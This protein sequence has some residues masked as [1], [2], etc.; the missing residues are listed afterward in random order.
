[1]ATQ[2][3]VRLIFEAV[4]RY[5]AVTDDLIKQLD[6]IS[7]RAD[8]AQKGAQELAESMRRDVAED[9]AR[10]VKGLSAAFGEVAKGIGIAGAEL[11]GFGYTL[12]R[13]LDYGETGAAI[14]NLERSFERFASGTGENA[15]R[16]LANMMRMSDGMLASSQAMQQYNRAF[17]L[18]DEEMAAEMPRF[19]QL[20]TAASA[21][22]KGTFEHMLSSL[23]IGIGRLSPLIL[24]NLGFTVRLSDAYATY[25]ASVGKAADELTKAEQQQAVLNAVMAQAEDRFGNLD[26]AADQ[27]AGKGIARLRAAW[28]ELNEE[29]NRVP[30]PVIDAFA[31][32]LASGMWMN[33]Q[34]TEEFNDR[35][36]TTLA[37][38]ERI[39][40]QGALTTLGDRVGLMAEAIRNAFVPGGLGFGDTLGMQEVIAQFDVATMSAEE[41]A[42]AI[43]AVE[44]VAPGAAAEMRRIRNE[45]L[46][47]AAE[48]AKSD[49]AMRAMGQGAH[50]AQVDLSALGGAVQNLTGYLGNMI[51]AAYDAR[52]ALAGMAGD[53]TVSMMKARDFAQGITKP[54]LDW[55]TTGRDVWELPDAYRQYTRDLGNWIEG[56]GRQ[57]WRDHE[58]DIRS[59]GGAYNDL[60]KDMEAYYESWQ[61]QAEGVLQPTQSF[62]LTALEDQLGMHQDKWDEAARR[63]MDVVNRGGESPWS[64]K[65]GLDSKEAALQY[66]R[67][68]YAGKLP[69]DVNWEAAI[70]QYRTQ[71]EGMIGQQN[72]QAMFQEKLVGAGLGPDSSLVMQALEGPFANAGTQSGDVF[73]SAFQG[74]DWNGLGEG[75]G[76]KIMTG[77]RNKLEKG[78]PKLTSAVETVVHRVI[79]SYIGAG[80]ELP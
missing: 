49:A 37:T 44:A 73:V 60:Q 7:E 10:G 21:A 61:S 4:N 78:D 35:L 2:E 28:R 27:M 52:G 25:A 45:A 17:L 63:A 74:L 76:D 71:M 70:D 62:D 46:G 43:K 75:T 53:L 31:E 5:S 14:I 13:V 50:T 40:N 18:M 24:D 12:N 55:Y 69:D 51:G 57:L 38:L 59:A 29:M 79:K 42:T 19:I 68:F 54:Q 22:G 23:T 15:D 66:V 80:G 56:Q 77:L 65:M 48:M 34:H 33:V 72:L 30:V 32:R 20:A 9:G 16:V 47:T 67:D 39:N 1:M 36:L 6:A 11:A 8:A 58:S 3:E 41:F 64:A 26:E